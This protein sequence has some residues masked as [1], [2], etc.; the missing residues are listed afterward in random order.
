MLDILAQRVN[1]DNVDE[2][3][4]AVTD[5]TQT[6]LVVDLRGWSTSPAAA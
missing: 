3:R 1:E 5:S 6:R 2:I 4:K